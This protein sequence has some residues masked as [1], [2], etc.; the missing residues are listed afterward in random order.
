METSRVDFISAYCDRWCERCAY[1]ARCSAFACHVAVAMCGDYEE[2]LELAVGVPHPVDGEPPPRGSALLME[3]PEIEASPDETA[4]YERR[5]EARKARIQAAPLTTMSSA[6]AVT[7]HRWLRDHQDR[8]TAVADPVL[9][10]ALELVAYD[11]A[12]VGAKLHR[13]MDGRDRHEHDEEHLAD[14]PVQN[15]WNGS[16]KVALISIE[17]SELAW[18]IIAQATGDPIPAM[19]A[20][21][22]TDLMHV[23][24]SEFPHAESF[25]R[26]GFD[27]PWR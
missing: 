15:D 19:L 20:D 18:R 21:G 5:D 22:L 14:D 8:L 13:A 12:F 25:V 10:E 4:E 26:P 1:T 11:A 17:R 3:V 24:H 2:G 7:S 6:Y 9:A 16:A 23:L 27:E